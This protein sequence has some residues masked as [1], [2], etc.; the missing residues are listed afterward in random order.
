MDYLALLQELTASPA[1][2]AY[3]CS[4]G[5]LRQCSGL[6]VQLLLQLL[7]SESELSSADA[8]ALMQGIGSDATRAQLPRCREAG[9]LGPLWPSDRD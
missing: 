9:K 7:E 1:A 8:T 5:A 4:H 6:M 3:L 2:A